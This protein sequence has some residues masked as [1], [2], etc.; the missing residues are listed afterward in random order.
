MSMP[1]TPVGGSF[2]VPAVPA[3]TMVATP[4]ADSDV[5]RNFT[6]KF[7]GQ[8]KDLFE[9][10]RVECQTIET[11]IRDAELEVLKKEDEAF[12]LQRNDVELSKLL[13]IQAAEVKQKKEAFEA[14]L[15]ARSERKKGKSLMTQMFKQIKVRDVTI[16]QQEEASRVAALYKETLTNKRQAFD[17]LQQ[18]LEKKHEKQRKQVVAAQ[19]RKI[20]YEKNLNDLATRH[21]RP[22]IRN[23]MAKKFGVRMNHQRAL[24]KRV[25]DQ[26]RE[27]QQLEQQQTKDRFD[28]DIECFEHIQQLKSD[29]AKRLID[30][31]TTQVSEIHVEKEKIAARKEATV[32]TNL[33]AEH[34]AEMKKLA[35]LHRTQLR[36]FKKQSDVRE[37]RR[38]RQQ[39]RDSPTDGLVPPNG[40][41]T[42]SRSRAGSVDSLH[43][44]D[45]SIVSASYSGRQRASSLGGSQSGQ[46]QRFGSA[47]NRQFQ[48]EAHREDDEH[49]D[50]DAAAAS[51]QAQEHLSRESLRALQYR[52]RDDRA[53]LLANFKEEVSDLEETVAGRKQAL[54]EE[55]KMEMDRMV[56]Q[57]QSDV[58]AMLATQD[59]EVAMEA[60]IH[61]AEMKMLLERRILNSVLNTV[62]DGVIN[63]DPK[64]TVVR[65]NAA[66]ENMFGYQ[67][68]EVIGKNIKM[69]MPERFSIDHDSYLH[70]YMTTGVRKVIGGGRR[71]YGLRKD[72][73]EFPLHLSVSEVKE[74]AAH[75][76]TGIVRD[77]TVEVQLEQETRAKEEAKQKELGELVA[78][79]D[80]SQKQADNLLKEMLP[81]SIAQQLMNGVRVAPTS[82]EASTIFFSDI[83]GFT[84]ISSSGSPLDTVKLLNDLYNCFDSIIAR[85]DAYKVETIGDAY[86]VVSGVPN[87]NGDKHA[88]EIATMALEFLSAVHTKTFHVKGDPNGKIKI[89][90]GLNSGPVVAGVVGMKMPRY[91]LF[92]DTVNTASRMESSGVPMKIHISED[93]A[94]ALERLGGYHVQKRGDINVKVMFT[95][96]IFLYGAEFVK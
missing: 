80:K 3:G 16:Q 57:H 41:S 29:H 55:Q 34:A 81:E 21:L 24:D 72:G 71:A 53:Q 90:I 83:V 92:G 93:T 82:F 79:L 78:K 38:G 8:T 95:S 11:G 15:K 43:S 37:D 68:I 39:Q 17:A 45:Q 58:A 19:E 59:K 85:H 66:A 18:H 36:Q 60:S 84:T 63:I 61:D 14:L 46:Q 27:V 12:A 49:D 67:A 1:T 74:D 20:A 25:N 2:P 69:L 30:L 35:Q 42:Y 94:K 33:Q 50:P 87:P 26:L 91:C 86:M 88:G 76:F 32:I 64:G 96:I 28:L 9:T 51:S 5:E 40:A 70:N 23:A 89:R 65:F 48:S 54:E 10:L 52:H 31:N 44:D 6:A 56:R 62:V 77:L 22:E 4:P 7:Q 13:G 47:L 75:L 73:S